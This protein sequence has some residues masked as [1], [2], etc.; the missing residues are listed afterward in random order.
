MFFSKVQQVNLPACSPLCPLNAERQAGI[1]VVNT[2]I[3]VIGLTR[4]GIKPE[5]AAPEA[6]VL[7]TC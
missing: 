7:A 2:N 6:D 5:T 3:K 1:E 4:L